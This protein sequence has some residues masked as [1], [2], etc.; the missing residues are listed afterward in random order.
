MKPKSELEIQIKFLTSEEKS[1]IQF[2]IDTLTKLLEAPISEE[3]FRLIQNVHKEV[4]SLYEVYQLKILRA[5][6]REYKLE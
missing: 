4:F 6:K 3:T 2:V 1:K 5:L